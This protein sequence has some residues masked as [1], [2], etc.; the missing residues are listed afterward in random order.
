[1]HGLKNSDKALLEGFRQSGVPHQVLL[2]KVDRVL[3]H[4]SSALTNAKIQ[5]AEEALQQNLDG[6]RKKV[7]PGE[8]DGPEALGEIIGSSAA[9]TKKKGHFLG[10]NNIRWAVLVATGLDQKRQSLLPIN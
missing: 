6:L 4:P 1:M 10:I 5:K 2:S 3:P 9:K 7:Q 8:G